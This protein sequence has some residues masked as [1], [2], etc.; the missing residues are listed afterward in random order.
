M[1][2][3]SVPQSDSGSWRPRKD[4]GVVQSES[5]GQRTRGAEAVTLSPR[6]GED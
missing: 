5:E 3:E 1:A 6:A 4:N 2:K